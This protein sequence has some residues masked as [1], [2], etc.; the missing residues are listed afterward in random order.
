MN[1]CKELQCVVSV[2]SMILRSYLPAEIGL[3]FDDV[4]FFNWL[5]TASLFKLLFHI[6]QVFCTDSSSHLEM[7][8]CSV[9]RKFNGSCNKKK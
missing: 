9:K 4:Q 3:T 8:F 1:A 2:T 6:N 7:P 5:H